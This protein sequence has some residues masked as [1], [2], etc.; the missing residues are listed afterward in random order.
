MSK[1]S[2]SN[3]NSLY[4][5]HTEEEYEN[6][7]YDETRTYKICIIFMVIWAIA[8]FSVSNIRKYD[9]TQR[10][11][12]KNIFSM[13]FYREHYLQQSE[14]PNHATNSILNEKP[15]VTIEDMNV[16]NSEL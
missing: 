6:D 4:S 13:S 9:F 15:I 14:I 5:E 3:E 7:Y 16:N 10:A 8:M 12:G 1:K 11:Q 2:E